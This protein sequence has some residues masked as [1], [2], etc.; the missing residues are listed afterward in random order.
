MFSPQHPPSQIAGDNATRPKETNYSDP[1]GAIFSMY[2]TRALK[3]DHENVETWKGGADGILVF[4]GLFSSTVATFIAISY[5]TLQQD[6]NVTTQSLLTQISQQLSNLN[7]N[8]TNGSNL[9][10]SPSTQNSFSPSASVVFVNSVWFLSLV[11]SLTCAL[12]ATLMQQ[13][14]RRYLQIIQRN[15][16]PH[17]RAHIRE[18]FSRGAGKFRIF[19]VVELLPSLLLVSVLLF[20]AGL[21]VFAFL[22]NHTVA[23]ITL[24][25][26]GFSFLS[27]IALTLMPLI[28]QDCPYYTPL[29]S[30]LWFSSQ[31]IGLSFSSALHR[32]AKHLHQR[33]GTVSAKTVKL[34]HRQHKNKAKSW[35]EDVITK[36]ENSA[37]SVSMDIYRKALV[38]T[39]RQLDQDH[40]LEE[41]VAGIPGLYDSD[42]FATRD[43]SDVQRNIRPVLAVLP[44]P[45]SSHA[46]LPWS[47]IRI[48]QRAITSNLSKPIQQRRTQTCLR[49][50]YFIPGAIRDVLASYAAGK[51]YCLEILPLLN[52][53]ESLE[54][55]D[56]LWDTPNDDVALS[57]RCAAA[58]VTAFMIT[59]PRRT[60]DTFVTPIFGFIGNDIIGKQFLARR[61]SVC[62]NA[63]GGI[64]PEYYP[65]DNARLQNIVRFL[66]DIKDTL[67]YMNTQWWTSES[68][69]SICQERLALFETRH[70]EEYR[71]GHGT[72][73]QQGNRASPTFVPAAQQDL[74]TLTLEILA[75]DPVANAA[76]SHREAFRNV[77]MGLGEVTAQAQEQMD[78]L[79]ESRKVLGTIALRQVRAA[80]SIGVVR[81][82]LEPVLLGL[83]L[84]QNSTPRAGE[85]PLPQMPIPQIVSFVPEEMASAND[86][87]HIGHAHRQQLPPVQAP[88]LISQYSMSSSV[89]LATAVAELANSPFWGAQ[90]PDAE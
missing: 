4:T 39:L 40:E 41:F 44:G 76:R 14:A 6:P 86:T 77:C 64:V 3:F 10:A 65:S 23:Y 53:P 52:S 70:T 47:I 12:M 78:V 84:R 32:C 37:K 81:R 66:T 68:A 89:G 26:V 85:T 50:L 18:Y 62:S 75:R 28:F 80:D 5:P 90:V 19:G 46:S 59:P 72:F 11:L 43:D 29:T 83:S 88:L 71:N 63:N 30:V 51:H 35:S 22:A 8:S 87:A 54:I 45:T 24:V 34:F 15:H 42:A 74:I 7:A 69:D 60:L 36:L 25:I 56:E 1:S 27:Y 48:A 33:W 31:I 16:A 38:W 79:S 21:V 20:F 82:A 57:V 17:V 13:W 61:F 49:A 58:V 2:I 9:G 67:Q 55:I 73:D